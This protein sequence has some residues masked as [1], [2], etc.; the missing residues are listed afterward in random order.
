M[1]EEK[2]T[3]QR[4]PEEEMTGHWGREVIPNFKGMLKRLS[5]GFNCDLPVV[6]HTLPRKPRPLAA[7]MNW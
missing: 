2:I 1:A 3:E 7:G 5:K 4:I 6:I